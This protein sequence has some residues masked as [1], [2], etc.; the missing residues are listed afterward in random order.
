VPRILVRLLGI[1]MMLGFFGYRYLDDFSLDPG[2]SPPPPREVRSQDERIALRVGSN[3]EVAPGLASGASIELHNLHLELNLVVFSD[4]SVAPGARTA[5]QHAERSA[6]PLVRAHPDGR[7]LEGPDPFESD[8]RAAVRYLVRGSLDGRKG[9][10]LHTTIVGERGVYHVIAW[11]DYQSLTRR[12]RAAAR[13][14]AGSL[15]EIPADER[16]P[17]N[18]RSASSDGERSSRFRICVSLAR[19]S[20]CDAGSPALACARA[21]ESAGC[22][23]LDPDERCALHSE[24]APCREPRHPQVAQ[25]CAR[26]RSS[27]GCE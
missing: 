15:R 17:R 23:R 26:L 6:R 9:A 5:L 20:R 12:R 4:T 13:S 24:L 18:A 16:A 7:V 2:P 11:S 8:G 27:A 19:G 3:W 25:L 22:E 21:L 10:Y 14:V 1:A